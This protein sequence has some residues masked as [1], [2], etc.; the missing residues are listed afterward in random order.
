MRHNP[1]LIAKYLWLALIAVVIIIAVVVVFEPG[2]D[3][4]SECTGF[5]YF[6]FLSQKMTPDS[7][8]L[9]L[10]NGPMDIR[11]VNMTIEGVNAGISPMNV[12]AG[13]PFILVPTIDPTNK[14]PEETFRYKIAVSY[15]IL[16]GIGN[17]KDVA[18]CTGKVQ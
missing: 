12:K 15:D 5:Q 16:T 11:I 17:N 8:N 18:I 1:D 2:K 3:V 4:R 10:L 6:L 14:M 13:E 9:Q 7:L